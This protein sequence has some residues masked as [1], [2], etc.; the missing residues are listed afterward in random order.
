[1]KAMRDLGLM[2]LEPRQLSGVPVV[3]REVLIDI[4]SEQLR[5]PEGDDLV[6]MR[7]IVKG[8]KEGVP[9]TVSY[10]LVDYHDEENG[11]TAMMRTTGYSLAATA[12]LQASGVIAVG[13]H[14]CSE[15]RARRRLRRR[16]AGTRN[17]DR[18][19]GELAASC[20]VRAS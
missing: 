14:T 20:V 13:V 1:M 18:A 11:V 2:D 3:P 17:D 8:T 5:S 16:S 12:Y 10:E 19:G 4:L 6:A 9:K 7:V 15:V